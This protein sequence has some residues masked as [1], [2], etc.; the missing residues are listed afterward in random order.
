[1]PYSDSSLKDVMHFPVK[2]C[3]FLLTVYV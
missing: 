1:M 3:V 2:S